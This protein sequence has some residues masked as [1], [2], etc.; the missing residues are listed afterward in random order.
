MRWERVGRG[1]SRSCHWGDEHSIVTNE[2]EH[3][4]GQGNISGR[5]SWAPQ[6]DNQCIAD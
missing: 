6:G 4:G 1:D 2:E 3:L 5:H